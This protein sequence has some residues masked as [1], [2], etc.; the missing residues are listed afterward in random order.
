MRR[1]TTPTIEFTVT[2]EDGSALDLTGHDI[3]ITF[4]ENRPRGVMLTKRN[5][6]RCVEVTTQGNASIVSVYLTQRE[7]LAF[8]TGSTIRA[9]L[10]CKALGIAIATDIDEFQAEEIL[11][12]GEI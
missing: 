12:E 8:K 5:T 9:Q 6:D 10:R 1:G 3:Y 7:T 11:L 4:K 2:N